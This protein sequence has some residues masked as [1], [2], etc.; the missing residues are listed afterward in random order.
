MFR[1]ELRGNKSLFFF[2]TDRS[3]DMASSRDLNSEMQRFPVI[4]K[5]DFETQRGSY[6]ERDDECT[7]FEGADYDMRKYPTENLDGYWKEERT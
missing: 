6:Q 1:Q 7:R 5:W 4:C 3:D 2:D